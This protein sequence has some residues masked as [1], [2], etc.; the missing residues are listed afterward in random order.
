MSD[1]RKYVDDLFHDYRSTKRTKDL[2][3]EIHG[4]LE[5]RKI[6]L[7]GEGYNEIEAEQIACSY[8]TSIDDLMCREAEVN[9]GAYRLELTQMILLG[10]LITWIVS[11]PGILFR[12]LFAINVIA[13]AAVVCIGIYYAYLMMIK[14]KKTDTK[15]ISIVWWNRAAKAVWIVAG[16]YVLIGLVT[17]TGI[18]FG[19][20]FW[21]HRPV[22]IDGPY[23]FAQI[24][25]SY[26]ASVYVLA[27]PIIFSSCK[28]IWKKHEVLE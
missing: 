14:K 19:S 16:T 22:K 7:M 28:N 26:L 1:L 24:L 10:T 3:E 21:F 6:D 17:T 20:N 2:K 11:I 5:A 8:I 18:Y 12:S 27:I 25:S 13:F 23:Q 15:R 9:N 4:N